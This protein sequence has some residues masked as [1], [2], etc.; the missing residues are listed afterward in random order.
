MVTLNYDKTLE[1]VLYDNLIPQ[2]GLASD[3]QSMI[4]D[5]SYRGFEFKKGKWKSIKKMFNQ[6]FSEA[7][8]PVPKEEH[9]VVPK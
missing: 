7:P 6:K 1:V 4:P 3:K 9:S 5:G 2:S 8:L